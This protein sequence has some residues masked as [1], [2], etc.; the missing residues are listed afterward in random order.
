MADSNYTPDVKE[1]R[2]KQERGEALSPDEQ[3]AL[4]DD[5]RQRENDA[6]AK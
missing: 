1:I 5:N 4:D 3:S 6:S 2:K